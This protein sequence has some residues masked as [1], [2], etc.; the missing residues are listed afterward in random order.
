MEFYE[1]LRDAFEADALNACVT[2][3]TLVREEFV[4]ADSIGGDGDAE[5]LI[6][7]DVLADAVSR[8]LDNFGARV[9]TDSYGL[10]FRAPTN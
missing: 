8:I 1:L 5:W 9:E 6:G 10:V 2:W 3:E 4:D 7:D